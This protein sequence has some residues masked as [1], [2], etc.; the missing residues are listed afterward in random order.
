MGKQKRW[1]QHVSVQAAFIIAIGGI[2]V[3]GM[4]ICHS[5]SKIKQ[6]NENYQKEIKSKNDHI[7]KLEQ[8]ISQRTAEIQ[9]LETQLTPFKAIALEKYTGSEQEALQKLAK[10]IEKL[11][12]Q[13]NP[14]KKPIAS[15]TSHVEV[16]IKSDEQID[17]LYWSEGGLLAF[18][19]NNQPLLVT[20]ATKSKARQNGKGEVIYKGDFQM[21]TDLSAIG[22]PIEILQS[23]DILIVKFA[24]IPENSKVVSGKAY[25]VINGNIR[26]EFEI[27]PQDMQD[28]IIVIHDIENAFKTKQS[29][30]SNSG[31]QQPL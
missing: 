2:I 6:D 29:T 13:L 14:L 8:Q 12:N 17:T 25:A 24:K 22:K 18:V 31:V 5:R 20:S 16:T 30:G 23:S 21:Q 28:D 27:P 3:A 7:N 9:R 10:K 4:H 26:L 19:K 1:Y 15:A 11:K